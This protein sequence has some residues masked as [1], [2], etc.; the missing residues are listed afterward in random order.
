MND[1]NDSSC[2]VYIASGCRIYKVLVSPFHNVF[3]HVY[4]DVLLF[5]LVLLLC[6]LNSSKLN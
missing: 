4:N 2:W 3:V 6:L 5:S 1:D